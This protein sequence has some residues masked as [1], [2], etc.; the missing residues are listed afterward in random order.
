MVTDIRQISENITI[1]LLD[2]G[3]F[4]IT[5]NIIVKRD[6]ERAGTL[7]L[8]KK[9]LGTDD[10]ELHY[11]DQK[12]PFLKDSPFH[13][14]ISH[15]HD[16]LVI[17]LDKENPTGIDIELLRDKVIAIRHKFLNDTESAWAG[18]DVHRLVTIWAAKECMYKAHGLKG[19]DFRLHLFVDPENENG[20]T[21]QII[22]DGLHK[23]YRLV[24]ENI[25]DYI[26]VYTFAGLT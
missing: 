24:K 15:S 9:L 19:L 20:L 18:N 8:L 22:K 1:G 5:N 14:S 3:L 11:T 23:K 17:I 25:E 7:Y 12:K 2:L 16:K 21:G 26:M 6:Q 10:F 13:I 4:S